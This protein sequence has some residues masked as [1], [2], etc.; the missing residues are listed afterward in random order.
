VQA[1]TDYFADAKNPYLAVPDPSG[2]RFG[3]Y[4]PLSRYRE[5]QDQPANGKD[6]S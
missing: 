6:K 4:D 5:W 3:D 1:L 2:H